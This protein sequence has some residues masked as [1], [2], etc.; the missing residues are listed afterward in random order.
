MFVGVMLTESERGEEVEYILDDDERG[1]RDI[2]GVVEICDGRIPSVY[3]NNPEEFPEPTLLFVDPTYGSEFL[4]RTDHF[5][6]SVANHRPQP[7]Y[8]FFVENMRE[9]DHEEAHRRLVERGVEIVLMCVL[10]AT[11]TDIWGART[12][13]GDQLTLMDALMR[14]SPEGGFQVIADPV[15]GGGWWIYEVV[16]E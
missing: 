7:G 3:L 1:A 2:S 11:K 9:V 14:G 5:I 12:G 8:R 15:Q 16:D 13:P 4:Y 6:L 10:D